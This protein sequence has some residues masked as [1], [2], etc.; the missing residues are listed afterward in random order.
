MTALLTVPQVAERLAVPPGR[1]YEMINAGH[2]KCVRLPA[3]KRTRK[4]YKGT[5][6]EPTQTAIRVRESDLEAFLD[7]L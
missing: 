5:D 4:A 2:L 6:R 3:T 1:V 7:A